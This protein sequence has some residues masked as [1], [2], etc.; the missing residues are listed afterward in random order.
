MKHFDDA[1]CNENQ[2]R[3]N[4]VKFKALDDAVLLWLQEMRGKNIAIN[5]PLLLEKATE[6]AHHLGETSFRASQGWLTK[7]KQRHGVICKVVSGEAAAVDSEV[8]STWLRTTLPTLLSRYSANDIYNADETGIFFEML[9]NKTLAFKGEKCSGGKESK[10]R[11]TAMVCANI[12]GT[13]GDRKITKT[14]LLQKC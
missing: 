4:R 12:T 14:S 7:F 9:P 13:D 10:T 6:F 3:M 8:T 2:K 5:G 1:T 11:I